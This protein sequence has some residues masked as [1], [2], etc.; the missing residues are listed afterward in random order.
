[1]KVASGTSIQDAP[2]GFRAVH[3]DAALILNVF[4]NYTYTLETIIQAGRRDIPIVSVP[5]KVNPDLRPSR[6]ISSV[7]K[8]VARSFVTICRIFITYKPARFFALLSL[9]AF[10]PGIIVITRFFFFYALGEGA[11]H[12]QS[13][14]LGSGLVAIA[15][16]LM[17]AG[18][19]ADLIS[20]NRR[21]L[22]DTRAR[23]FRLELD[24]VPPTDRTKMP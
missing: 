24:S 4:N 10:V 21:L 18:V 15:A 12:V 3:R 22:E 14:I 20:V 8:Y 13:L 5:I 11:G 2:S 9:L 23:L 17:M 6:L 1:V 19:L 7:P 16:I